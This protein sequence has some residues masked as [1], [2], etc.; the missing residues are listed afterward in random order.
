MKLPLS[1]DSK[2][3][4][5]NKTIS[6]G[7]EEIRHL[8]MIL[9][10]YHTLPVSTPESSPTSSIGSISTVYSPSRTTSFGSKSLTHTP[11]RFPRV[12]ANQ[13]GVFEMFTYNDGIGAGQTT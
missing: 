2:M 6:E 11:S 5:M 1:R 4:K 12:H 13:E 8:K 10:K 9:S 7:E 3:K